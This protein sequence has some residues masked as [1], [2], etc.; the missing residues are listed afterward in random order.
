MPNHRR[1]YQKGGTCF[2][3]V[4]TGNRAKI[5]CGNMIDVLRECIKDCMRVLS[6]RTDAIVVLPDHL[7]CLWSLPEGDDNFSVRWK[8]IK[9]SF[10]KHYLRQAD[11]L[12][13]RA[14]GHMKKKGEAGVWQRR[15]WEHTIRDERDFR[16][17]CDYIHYNPVKH[18]YV[19][20]PGDWPYSSFSKYV[21]QGFYDSGWGTQPVHFPE[22][23][24]RE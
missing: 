6:F 22:M 16:F 24:I 11:R 21:A 8:H 3:T 1:N 19:Q 20:A 5:L 13:A 12:E 9:A 7:H 17:H 2:F 4:V 23:F 18:G 15:F 14:T 10:T